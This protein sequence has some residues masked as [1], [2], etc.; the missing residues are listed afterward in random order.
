MA[1]TGAIEKLKAMAKDRV[2]AKALKD[3][4]A[5]GKDVPLSYKGREHVWDR[6]VK[7]YAAG[8]E[9][10]MQAGGIAKIVKGAI[11]K[12]S[13]SAGM[14]APVVAEKDLT[15]LQDFHTSL[16]DR[17]RAGAEE[18][19]KMMEG[20]DYKYDKGQRVFTKDSAAKNRPPYTI[21][22]RTRVGNVPMREDMGDLLSKKVI[23]P[24][25]GRAKRTP[26]EP[27][28]RVR[29]EHGPEDTWHEFVIPASAIIGDVGMKSGGAV[30]MQ[31]GGIARLAKMLKGTQEVLPAAEREA[32]LA[33]MLEPS[34]V[35]SR[36]YHGTKAHDEYADQPGQAFEQFTGRPTWLAQEPY[37][38]SG[39]SGGT[40]STYPVFA[41]VKNPLNLRFDANDDANKAFAAAKRLGVDVEHI[42]RMEKPE[43]AWQVINHPSFIDAVERAGYDGLAI[44]EGGYKTFGVL[45]PRKI[46][47]ATGNR[48]TYDTTNPNLNKAKG[49]AVHMAEGG[50]V[51][52]PY[53]GYRRAGR[54]PESQQDRAASAN[55]P[56]AVARGLV[57]G[58]L[59]MPGDL[60]SLA[61]IPYDYFRSP[62][63]GELVTGDKTSKT[64]LPTSED[65]EK[66]L[67]FRGA[68]QTPVGQ[69]FTGASQ[70]A[71]GA[72]TGPLSGARAA[73]AVPKAIKRA[74]QD[75]AMAS[76]QGVPKMFIG[77]KAKTWDQAK[78]DAAARMEQEGR[79][80]VDIWRQTGTFRGADGIQRQEISD[81]G[82][83]HRNPTQLKELGKQ[84]KE[85]ANE[86][87]SRLFG[88]PWQK[89]M[90]P[91]ALTEAKKPVREKIKTLKEEADE[92][93]RLSDVRG[94]SAKFALEHPELYKAY[95]EL[96]EMK[97]FQG[98]RGLSGERASL[99][100]DKGGV[101]MNITQDGLRYDPRSSALHEMQHAVQILEDMA[102]GGMP[103]LAFRDP[104]AF[105]ILDEL[106]QRALTPMSFDDY[107]KQY[108]QLSDPKKGY[109]DYVK[110]IPNIVKGMDR[111]L[112]KEAAME[113][114]KRLAGEAEARATQ[115]REPMSASQRAQ[116]FP[117]SS[118]DVLPEDL[119]VKPAR[120]DPLQPE[121]DMAE[122]GEV[123]MAGGGAAFGRYTTGKKY[124]GAVKRA[125]EA[126]VNT[127]AD[128]RTYA[129][130]SG[131][132]GSA[133]DQLGF[134]VM[135][136]DYKNIQ[137][138]GERGFMGGTILGVAPAVAPLTRGLPVGA[139]IKPKGGNFLTGSVEKAMQPL[140]RYDL[141]DLFPELGS[142]PPN[143]VANEA[144]NQWIDRNLTNY[145]KKEMATPE[146]PVR[147]LAEQGIVHIPTE[148]VGIN[149]YK[150]PEK[151]SLYGGE[152]LGQSEAAKAWEDASDV[153]IN[154][155]FA[156][157]M[158]YP[159]MLEKN[160]WLSKL[161]P[162]ERVYVLNTPASSNQEISGLGFDHIL[163]VLKQDLASGRIR[164]EQLNKVSME[165]AV[166]RTYD[167]DQDMAKKMR[168]AQ[169]KATEG[170]P[171][172]KEY[173]EG[174]K[175]VELGPGKE[176]PEG[177]TTKN[178]AYYD[179][180]GERHVHPDS[181][182]VANAL[183]YEGDTMG[184][185]V[186]GYCPDVL[187]GR[188]RI[189][190]LRDA[191]G[192]PHVTVEVQP[193]YKNRGFREGERPT[194]DEYYQLQ[195]KYVQG[196]KTGE[197]DP[198]LTFAEWWRSSK[199]IPEEVEP[200][201]VIKQI[202]GKQNRAPNE[203]YLPFVQDFVRGGKWS[204]VGDLGNT[205]LRRYDA[206]EGTKYVTEAEYYDELLKELGL[207]PGEGMKAGGEVK[208]Q[209]GGAAAVI[210]NLLGI[211]QKGKGSAK[212]LTQ[213]EKNALRSQGLGVPGEDFADVMNPADVMRMSE[214]LGNAGAEGKMLNLTQADR[215]RVFGT[216]K[217]G[218]GFSGLQLTSPAHQQAGTTWGVGKPGHA[219]RLINA[220][221]PDTIW[222]TFIGS[223]TQHMSNPVT[224]ERMFREHMKANPSSDLTAKMNDKLNTAI[225]PKTKKPIFP[226]GIDVSSP[227][228]LASANTFDQRKLLAETLAGK[229][230]GGPKKGGSVIDA[231]RIIKEETDPLLMGSPT[232]AVGNRL[233]TIDSN[234]GIYRPDL[235]AAFPYQVT[236]TDLGMVFEPAP[237]ELAARD[238]VSR[239]ADR[240]NKSGKIQPM[241][242]K[243]LTATTPKQFVGEDYLTFL[244]KEGYAK[245]GK[246]GGLSAI[247][248]V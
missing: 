195:E 77:P 79:D 27:G 210:K 214:A 82:A 236:G 64:F 13:Q 151:R 100:G 159:S 92:L 34:V 162:Q 55:I 71:G 186:G 193:A 95:P 224:V 221:T 31:A 165:Q 183:K 147:R 57:S 69:M 33:K 137:R 53:I 233:W 36:L 20:F 146:D 29:M 109:E 129:F 194:G 191:K 225:H 170:M 185:C 35:K 6:K 24:E 231:E 174:Y 63:M 61:R 68:S 239:Y 227:S 211:G 133:P 42:R 83:V 28:Y 240:K 141:P 45:D 235:N 229:G 246:V 76:T 202:K 41:Q 200:A 198:N 192:E 7:K 152:Q 23:D 50:K 72:Y 160:P 1:K 44:N 128:P 144:L 97:V 75:F 112:Q 106:R 114:Y 38:A 220:N 130:V 56:V 136:P 153:A 169:I 208:M 149:R 96:G 173:P 91:K 60:E 140:K 215:S 213:A 81:V 163:D 118:Y 78:A 62:T 216:N 98:M 217:G 120:R 122:G 132:L 135:H 161:D 164:P 104:Q 37:T 222:T 241:G 2:D 125:R 66:R 142:P 25:T 181:E 172:H 110:S 219:S 54:R 59:G 89:D 189:Y 188:S 179:P 5:A 39:Y 3:F 58:T 190:S 157:Q 196:Q 93:G 226:N 180:K 9:A 154:A 67:P 207:N 65:I 176:L 150:A 90:F 102:P 127:L 111:E 242:H 206:P 32:N 247:K 230:V 119:I 70:L 232:Y 18:A 113:Y 103:T 204:D 124:Q 116:E 73:M 237:V 85:E 94:Q 243:D 178:G 107:A 87:G 101:E 203:E 99:I 244:Q 209:A 177:W 12:A 234:T 212:S 16:G 105:K 199:G 197:V 47:S 155:P 166:R 43:K 187:E 171:V 51:D 17:V 138:V 143:S 223:P 184:H 218:T 182:K 26:Y 80:P 86:L 48:G 11:G 168:E 248:K 148:Q 139:T 4:V 131:L 30:H 167:F 8:G 84:K 145:I 201:P 74:G 205:G 121:L 158:A 19:R 228:A 117:Y 40:G 156:G 238:F 52:K 134:S 22:E 88:N 126:D 10:K 21:I 49:G 175:W 115:A 245:G 15:T 123:K 46:K 108:N 14:K